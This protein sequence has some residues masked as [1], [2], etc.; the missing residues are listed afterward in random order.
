MNYAAAPPRERRSNWKWIALLCLIIAA[1]FWKLLFTGQYSIILSWEGTNQ[2]YSWYSY[3]TR[4]I[5]K[6]IL[7]AWDPYTF[8]GHSYI[9]ETQTGLFYPLKALL[10]LAPVRP[11]G[12]LSERIFHEVF[13]LAHVL[14][15]IF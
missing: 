2:A 4:T 15:G 7:P 5:Q 11:D 10:Y 1:S 6:G 8:S 9:G 12:A 14:A 13:V 3:A